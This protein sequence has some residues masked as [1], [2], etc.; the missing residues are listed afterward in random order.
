MYRVLVLEPGRYD[1]RIELA[2]F[3]PHVFRGIE[4]TVGQIGVYDAE[5]AIGAVTSSVEVTASSQV[6]EPRRSQQ[7]NTIT[8]M[9]IDAQPNIN[10]VFS[11]YV[12]TLPGV[13]DADA[14]RSQNPGFVWPTG[15]FSIGGNNGRNNLITVDG[16]EHE[17]GTGTI[18]TPLNVASIQ[19][20]QVNRNG[21]AAEFGFTAGTA[22]N[23]VTKSGTNVR[24]GEG[25]T[26][27]RSSSMAARNYFDTAPTPAHNQFVAPG[28]AIGGPL[29]QNRLFGFAAVEGLSAEQDRFH[30][31]LD[32]P[33]V[34]GPSSNP[35]AGITQRA[36][37]QYLLQLAA[38]ADPNIRRI[39]GTLRETLTTANYAGTMR[40][41]RDASGATTARDRRQHYIGRLDSQLNGRDVVTARFSAFRAHTDSSFIAPT[42]MAA[43]SAGSDVTVRDNAALVTWSRVMSASI[44]HQ[45]RV[46]AAFNDAP[47]KAKSQA[48]TMN[49]DGLGTFGRNSG[50]PIEI[51]Q[52]RFQFEDTLSILHKRH[53]VKVGASYR[54]IDYHVRAELLFGG[55]WTFS[56]GIYPVL[57]AVPP[58]DQAALIAFN[59]ST[60]DPA[61]GDPY[62]P[63]GP[64]LAALNGLEAFNLGLPFLMAQ[65]FNNPVWS[66]WAHY[67]GVFAQ[68][69]WQ[70]TRRLT[71]D[72]GLRFDRESEPA[73]LVARSFLS[74]RLGLAWDLAGDQQTIVR[75][76]GGLFYAPIFFQV[77][78]FA[79]LLDDSGRYINQILVTPLSPQS[80]IALWQA[81]LAADKLPSQPLTEAD[82]R[83]FGVSIARGAPGRV[84]FD[85][86]PNYT[87]PYTIQ[88]SVGV[89]RQ[90]RQNLSIEVAYLTYRG[91]HLGLSQEAN[92][93]ETGFVDPLLGPAYAPIDPTIIQR[94]MARSIGRSTYDGLTM[95]LA[96]RFSRGHQY[97]VN[98]AVS[99][100]TDNVTDLDST[101]S[102]FMPTRFERE[103]ADS[104]F[105][106]RHNFSVNAV[107]QVPPAPGGNIL[108]RVVANTT[109]SPV[110]ALHSGL[111]FTLRIGRDI[112]GDTH[113][114]YDRPFMADRNT[115]RGAW[116]SSVDL[117]VTKYFPLG[118]DS[119]VRAAAVAEVI[120]VFNRTNFISVNDVIGTDPQYLTGPFDQT[121]SAAIPPTSPL[122]FNVAAPGRQLQVGVKVVF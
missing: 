29:K 18:R 71:L 69:S 74:P 17:Y 73:P 14:P 109:V 110:F 3:S 44:M 111:P 86:D 20:F 90:L 68:D 113:D 76:S 75:A 57:F 87:N 120:N 88:A 100:A 55:Q 23:V 59:L 116:F 93:S 98:Y 62:G 114:L 30:S 81:G 54:P 24:H 27:F 103:W 52:H 36:Q 15:G 118:R 32:N 40:M 1:V 121:G 94:N 4:L 5:L 51:D 41:L 43:E 50:V 101:F 82:L 65:G 60:L 9:Q 66:D 25:Y 89:T 28:G 31:F 47:I 119:R 112:N 16:G 84:I 95:S 96:K 92:Y 78:Q 97:Q 13:T 35:L 108:R 64:A 99:H 10:R 33:A 67:A 79:A 26:Y 56:S 61:T 80:P 34:D 45:A 49:I 117:R 6:S 7:A 38:S 77:P 107:L 122:G 46:Q 22:V 105:D 58:V 37:D 83:A 53:T 70:A 115:G 102:A 42:P 8:N 21:F 106:I 85:V 104:T 11:T 2:G 91:R 72:Y 63:T 39:G 48:P 19:E 12:L